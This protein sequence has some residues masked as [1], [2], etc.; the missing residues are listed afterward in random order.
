MKIKLNF[1]WQDLWIGI[2]VANK[3][4]ERIFYICLIPTICITLTFRKWGGKSW[5]WK[6]IINVKGGG[7][8][9]IYS[10]YFYN[11]K[12]LKE[13]LKHLDKTTKYLIIETKIKRYD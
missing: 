3:K 5:E 6:Q 8:Q 4:F 13:H 7:E 10:T 2:F 12:N 11:K 1:V 9:H